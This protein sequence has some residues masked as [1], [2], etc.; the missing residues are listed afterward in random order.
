PKTAERASEHFG[1]AGEWGLAAAN[2]ISCGTRRA[3]WRASRFQTDGWR[4]RA[5][6]RR[7][8]RGSVSD[9]TLQG[10]RERGGSR[11]RAGWKD[12]GGRFSLWS[13]HSTLSVRW[14]ERAGGV[15]TAVTPD[16][17]SRLCAAGER[18]PRSWPGSEADGY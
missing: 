3:R 13:K 17:Q 7:P 16:F 9:G 10:Y 15:A 2:Y 4:R 18:S 12:L 6:T 8:R 1:G 14:A 11:I 5:P